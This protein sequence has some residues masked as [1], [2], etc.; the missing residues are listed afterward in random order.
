MIEAREEAFEE[1]DAVCSASIVVECAMQ[2][3]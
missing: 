3:L 2:E 1:G